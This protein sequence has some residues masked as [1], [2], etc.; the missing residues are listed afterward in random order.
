LLV[1]AAAPDVVDILTA[2]M[3]SPM[4]NSPTAILPYP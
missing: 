2:S 1:V 3:D 4:L